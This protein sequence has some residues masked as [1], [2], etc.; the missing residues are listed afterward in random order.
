MTLCVFLLIASEFMPVSLL[1][2]IARDLGVTE[3]LAVL[4]AVSGLIIALASRYLVYMAG[5]AMMGIAIGGFWSMLAATAIRLVPQDQ[6]TR[7]LAIGELL[8][9]TLFTS[10]RQ[11]PAV[12]RGHGDRCSLFRS[13]VPGA[14]ER[15]S[16]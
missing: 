14:A 15:R 2:P 9:I 1:T 4:M 8:Q 16:P 12:L 11:T 5:R 10:H 3:G 7:A 13:R 6:V